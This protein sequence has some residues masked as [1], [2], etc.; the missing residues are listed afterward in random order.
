MTDEPREGE[1]PEVEEKTDRE[2]GGPATSGEAPDD[3]ATRGATGTRES[4]MEPH[5]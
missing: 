3:E 1:Q 2:E 4:G 5:E